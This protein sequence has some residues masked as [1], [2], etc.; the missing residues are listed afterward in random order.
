MGMV[1]GL[2]RTG[3][4]A[5]CLSLVRP[6]R[7]RSSSSR[8]RR[9]H[10]AVVGTAVT[11]LTVLAAVLADPGTA[12][13]APTAAESATITAPKNAVAVAGQTAAELTVPVPAGVRPTRLS[14]RIVFTGNDAGTATVRVNGR[15]VAVNRGPRAAAVTADV[16]PADVVNGT[17][18]VAVAYST[19]AGNAFCPAGDA[20]DTATLS[21]VRLA[22]TGAETA[23]ASVA[24]FFASSVPAV[25]VVVPDRP[26]PTVEAALA[27]V[28]AMA[29][30][31]PDAAVSVVPA[32]RA[33][34]ALAAL[35]PGARAVR[36]EPA[37]GETISRI[38]RT[39]STPTLT[40]T[41]APE[42]L[43]T[44]A[45]ALGQDRATALATGG[46]ARRLQAAVP[47][48]AGLDR[49]LRALG[50]ET[51]SLSGWGRRSQYIGVN[52]SQFGGPVSRLTLDLTGT[53]TALPDGARADLSVYWNDQL[54]ASQRLGDGNDVTVR[55]DIPASAL[56]SENGLRLQLSATPPGGACTAAGTTLPMQV[57][58]D[59]TASSVRAERGVSA[60]P[61]FARFPQALGTELPVVLDAGATASQ[62][63]ADGAALI[64][65]LQH[66]AAAQ[67]RVTTVD[68]DRFAGSSASG[69]VLGATAATA[70]RLRAPLRLAQFRTI[71][72]PGTGFGASA[73][74]PFAALEAFESNG[75][76]VLLLGSWAQ[77]DGTDAA[78]GLR[79][80]LARHAGA[81]QAGWSAL[82]R[83]L[84]IAGPGAEPVLLDSNGVVPQQTVTDDYAGSVW[85]AVG[86]VLA[87][88]AAG[89]AGWV[90]S[91]RR[92]TRRAVAFVDAEERD[93]PR[94]RAA[95]D[96]PRSSGQHAADAPVD[97]EPTAGR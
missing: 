96:A 54:V 97:A 58:F 2:D 89:T 59:T 9:P 18:N 60:E 27:L 12:V 55:A 56:R 13:A 5:A 34:T 36:L 29:H 75:R 17:L 11:V 81:Q 43:T 69:L 70:E 19:S 1:S 49:S 16:G 33:D 78:S 84:L 41:G 37:D 7:R 67:L 57:G 64:V 90:V 52:Q 93:D 95:G 22:T 88:V 26:D 48:T 53:H 63:L 15:D 83:N 24:A 46:E 8:V 85:W 30:R 82:S 92:R 21:D 77:A 66:K 51:V 14:A 38:G 39:G 47:G 72:D 94:G 50:A 71:G 23:P 6:K 76:Q 87:L 42:A 80:V 68:V 62:N 4:V 73:D 28:A 32:A 61:G 10:A 25:A 65:A 86:I 20:T 3:R 40:L 45:T 44:A 91:H 74:A 31:Y 79:S 35:P